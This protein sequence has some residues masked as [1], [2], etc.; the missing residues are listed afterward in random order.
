[1][2]RDRLLLVLLLS[3]AAAFS[4][5]YVVRSTFVEGGERWSMLLDDAMVSMRYARNLARGEGL[6]FNPGERVEGFSNPLWVGAMAVVH[7]LPLPARLAS[8]AVQALSALL[9][10]LGA[11]LLPALCRAL[12]GAPARAAP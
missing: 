12:P 1:M 4:A 3:A 2:R 6:V 7:L 10:L 5:R 11:A 8:L 9:L